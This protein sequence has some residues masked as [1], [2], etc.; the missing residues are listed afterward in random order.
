MCSCD[1]GGGRGRGVGGGGGV[2][3]SDGGGGVDGS[4]WNSGVGNGGDSVVY[5]SGGGRR[6]VGGVLCRSGWYF[7]IRWDFHGEGGGRSGT[8]G[9]VCCEA[10]CEACSV[11]CEWEGVFA[12]LF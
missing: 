7:G 9:G 10:R 4:G 1:G 2:D 6:S 8:Y 5:R 12:V 3:G 11:V